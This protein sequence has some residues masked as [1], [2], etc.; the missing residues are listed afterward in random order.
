MR[1]VVQRVSQAQVSVD[2]QIVG[3]VGPGLVVFLGVA[4]GDTPADADYLADKV[5][6]LRIFEDDQGRMNRSV[7]EADGAILVISQFTLLAD[8]RHGRRPSF[9]AAAAPDLGQ[10]LYEQVIQRLTAAGL[11]VAQGR[12]GARMHVLVDND[13]PVTI[14]LDSRKLF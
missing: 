6:G 5:A 10:R 7:T 3:R 9:T 14:L 1:A 4:D 8:A 12:F 13:G 2:G 11:P